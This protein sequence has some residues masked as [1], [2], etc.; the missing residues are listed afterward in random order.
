M[1]PTNDGNGTAAAAATESTP[2]KG[3]ARLARQASV[4][5][6][7][8][9]RRLD[10]AV[11]AL[12]FITATVAVIVDYAAAVEAV[13]P[14]TME[15]DEVRAHA[16][17]RRRPGCRPHPGP[18]VVSM[19]AVRPPA[20]IQAFV[21]QGSPTTTWLYQSLALAAVLLAACLFVQVRIGVAG[22]GGTHP[23]QC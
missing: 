4:A 16:D 5:G 2:L 14:I 19:G 6:V 1:G 13:A 15:E 20:R 21:S 17:V 9:S 8:V 11:A 7:S 22:T 10:V 23:R 18:P 3:A 12:C